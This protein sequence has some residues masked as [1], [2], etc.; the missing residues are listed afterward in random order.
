ME[1]QKKHAPLLELGLSSF[2]A[3]LQMR[4]IF[5][6][7]GGDYESSVNA[8]MGVLLGEPHWRSF[9]AR[10][11][12]PWLVELL[13]QVLPNFLIAHVAFSFLTL[14][15]M[16]VLSMRLGWRIGN[17]LAAGMFAFFIF[18]TSFAFLLSPHWFYS[19]DYTSIIVFLL[20]VDFVVSGRSWLWFVILLSV[21]IYSRQTATFIAVWMVLEGSVQLLVYRKDKEERRRDIAMLSAGLLCLFLSAVI[22]EAITRLLF[23]QEI[24][25]KIFN[26]MAGEGGVI[27]ALRLKSNWDI[28]LAAIFHPNL[29]L[30]IVII[31]FLLINMLLAVAIIYVDPRRY[32]ALGLTFVAH[33]LVTITFG[34]IS[35]TRIYVE[36]IPLIILATLLLTRAGTDMSAIRQQPTPSGPMHH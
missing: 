27:Q 20:F 15:V 25:P 6:L 8:S 35:E 16:G 11:L 4:L 33:E 18:Q 28:F 1:S 34:W 10:V 14:C 9:Q 24:G 29:N 7:F 36:Y 13:S 32:L 26:D 31:I 2:F 30:N 22:V 3:C 12:G 5:M 19:W 17:S 21:G 23:V